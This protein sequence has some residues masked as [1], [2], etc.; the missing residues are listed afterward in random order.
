MSRSAETHAQQARC[1][2][3][4]AELGRGMLVCV[5][6]ASLQ[7]CCATWKRHWLCCAARAAPLHSLLFRARP[8]LYQPPSP[9]FRQHNRAAGSASGASAPIPQAAAPAAAAAPPRPTGPRARCSCAWMT[10]P[11]P[12]GSHPPPSTNPMHPQC[13][14]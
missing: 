2:V 1:C 8:L 11:P 5:S 9:Q 7:Q 3:A 6:Y 10:T 14:S 12:S 13:A 4:A